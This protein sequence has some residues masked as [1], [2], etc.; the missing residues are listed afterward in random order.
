MAIDTVS[1]DPV[2]AWMPVPVAFPAEPWEDAAEWADAC[3]QKV[4]ETDT[5][6]ALRLALL[7]LQLRPCRCPER[8]SAFSGCMTSGI[9]FLLT[10]TSPTMPVTLRI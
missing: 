7:E 3:T 10:Y 6:D 8:S 9:R 4:P 1:I 5:R 2:E